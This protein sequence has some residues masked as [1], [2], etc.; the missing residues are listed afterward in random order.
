MKIRELEA[1]TL[2]TKHKVADDYF[3]ILYTMNLYRGCTHRC[4]YCDS[5]S[6]CYQIE[7]FDGEIL[8]K[9]NA[10]ELLQKELTPRRQKG[11]I[12]TGSMNDPYQ[13]VERKYQLTRQALEIIARRRFPVH[14]ITKSDLILRDIDLLQE[15]NREQ[16]LVSITITTADDTMGKQVEPFAPLSSKRL[17]ALRQLRD[18]GIRVG[19]TM[20]PVLPLILDTPGNVTSTIRQCAEHGAEYILPWM[21]MSLRTGQREYYYK[22]LEKSFPGLVQQYW[23]RYGYQYGAQSPRA[24]E[25]YGIFNQLKSEYGFAD[26][27]PSYEPQADAVQPGLF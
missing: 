17:A 24:D 8:V 3:G 22:E 19:V 11:R 25:L 20:Q 1:K 15:I 12:G 9:I 6:K 27:I 16:A 13:A 18:A 26:H 4:I 10:I 7:D 14:I 23:Q 2:L 5:R 21:G